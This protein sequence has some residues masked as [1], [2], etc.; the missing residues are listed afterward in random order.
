MNERL[1]FLILT[2]IQYNQSFYISNSSVWIVAS[3]NGFKNCIFLMIKDE[4]Q[5]LCV[6]LPFLYL[7]GLFAFLLNFKSYG[8]FS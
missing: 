3:H 2:K 5:F 4:E 6:Y 7:W 1:F 8:F